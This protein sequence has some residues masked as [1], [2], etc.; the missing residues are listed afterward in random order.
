MVVFLSCILPNKK[1]ILNHMEKFNR[2][3]VRWYAN[4]KK[5][6]EMNMVQ[7]T[8]EESMRDTNFS[9]VHVPNAFPFEAVRF[10]ALT[11]CNAERTP[12]ALLQHTWAAQ[13]HLD[14]QA[15]M[16]QMLWEKD[17]WNL[18][19]TKGGKDYERGFNQD[20]YDTKKKD[21]YPMRALSGNL[22]LPTEGMGAKYSMDD[23]EAYCREFDRD[24][25]LEAEVKRMQDE[26]EERRRA[27]LGEGTSY[28]EKD[29][30]TLEEKAQEEEAIR[31]EHEER[32]AKQE[33]KMK[34]ERERQRKE[35]KE[36]GAYSK[37]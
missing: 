27:L 36:K 4:V 12:E 33:K 16:K 24:E 30:R 19:V 22:F 15:Q 2:A 35:A 18:T 32:V 7:Y 8:K 3:G 25:D 17:F 20:Y 21:C 1:R 31:K 6:L 14:D 13:L 5:F 11:R 10:W 28:A 29:E 23:L 37:K 26:E 9:I 34:E